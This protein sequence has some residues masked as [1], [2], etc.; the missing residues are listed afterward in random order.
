MDPI[1]ATAASGLRSRMEA[2]EIL[3]NNMANAATSGY[4][5]DREFYGIYTSPEVQQAAV[6][7]G[8]AP[9][10][11]SMVERHW[12]DFAQ[13]ALQTTGSPLDV[14]LSGKGFL[15][16]NGPKGTLYTRNGSFQ[17][18]KGL[19][20]AAEGYP[21]RSESGG[22]FPIDSS[23]P[24]DISNDGRISQEGQ[25]LGKLQIVRFEDNASLQKAGNNYF[26]P[27]DLTT[28]QPAAD[29]QVHQGKL[30]N[31]NVGAAESAVR[32][33]GV[34]RQFE[35]LQRAIALGGEM[36]KRAIEEVARVGN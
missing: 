1:T 2:L 8:F 20:V 12:T 10:T 28:P 4:K 13:G 34:M 36:N 16:V 19:L 33:V 15:T 14:A 11:L 9:A 35:M 17:V 21:V 22:V 32:L 27:Q 31:S 30:E 18:S 6:D 3:A 26:R 29:V 25:T 24:F 23:K 5:S 7:E